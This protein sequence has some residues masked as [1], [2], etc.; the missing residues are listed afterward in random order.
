M[1]KIL[2]ADYKKFLVDNAKLS[3]NFLM[4]IDSG[5]AKSQESSL[6]SRF[7]NRKKI[8]MMLS[9]RESMN[10]LLA[11]YAKSAIY[12]DMLLDDGVEYV[13]VEDNSEYFSETTHPTNMFKALSDYLEP[14]TN[15]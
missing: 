8:A 6:W 2:C 10:K 7:L 1:Q 15:A 14:S 13:D 4:M 5:I 12:M 3:M 11:S 9:I